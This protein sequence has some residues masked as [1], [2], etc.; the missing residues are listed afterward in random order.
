S[1][2]QGLILGS[3]FRAPVTIVDD[4]V[5]IQFSGKFRNNQPE[6]VRTGPAGANVSVEY[7]AESGTAIL[8]EDFILPRGTLIFPPGVRSRL[9]PIRTVNDNIAEGPETFTITLFN[10]SP[11]AQLGPFFSQLFTLDDNDFGGTV[12]FGNTSV[13]A[14][15]GQTKSLNIVRSKDGAGT[16]MTVGWSA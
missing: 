11:P 6:V 2:P 13:T 5:V 7:V 8:G 1:N 16:V 3:P 14:A 10:P 4:E 12:G 15:P 9:I